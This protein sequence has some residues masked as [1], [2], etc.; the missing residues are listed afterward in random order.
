MHNMRA[1]PANVSDY[2][3]FTQM[4]TSMFINLRRLE[5]FTDKGYDSKSNRQAAYVHGFLPRIMKRKCRSSRR[6]NG[7]RVRVEHT[8][9]WIDNFRWLR[10]QYEHTP[11]VHLAYTVF[12]LGHLLCNRFLVHCFH[13]KII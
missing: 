2:K 11:H 9:G 4:L 8:F 10:V 7:K 12:A 5:V 1:D 3:L 13:L 6:Q